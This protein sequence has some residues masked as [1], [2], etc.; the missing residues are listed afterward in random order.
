[1]VAKKWFQRSIDTR[2]R[3]TILIMSYHCY[4]HNNQHG[5]RKNQHGCF[6]FFLFLENNKRRQYKC[7]EVPAFCQ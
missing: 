2:K 4:K 7:A 1:M 6:Y 3:K 5:N